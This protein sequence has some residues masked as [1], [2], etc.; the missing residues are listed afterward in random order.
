MW[1]D[2]IEIRDEVNENNNLLLKLIYQKPPILTAMGVSVNRVLCIHQAENVVSGF[3]YTYPAG[4]RPNHKRTEGL[5]ASIEA[6]LL[7]YY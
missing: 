1:K 3:S 5:V 7:N 2:R 6:H 4:V